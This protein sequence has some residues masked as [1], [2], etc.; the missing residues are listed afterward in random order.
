MSNELAIR[1]NSWDRHNEIVALWRHGVETFLELGKKLYDFDSDECWDDLNYASMKS[2]L[3]DADNH[4][5]LIFP[6]IR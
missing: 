2:Y 4:R 3:A 6:P 1:H 5:I